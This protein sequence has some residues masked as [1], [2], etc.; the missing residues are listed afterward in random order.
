MLSTLSCFF[1]ISKD[2]RELFEGLKISRRKE[3]CEKW[4]NR[5]PTVFVSFRRVDGFS[6]DMAYGCLKKI[7]KELFHDFD[8][9]LESDA[10]RVED[11]SD[12]RKIDTE[13]GS[14][15]DVMFSL[16]LLTRMLRDHY[17]KKVVLLIDEYDVPMAKAAEKGYYREMLSVMKGVLS[18][19]KDNTSLEFSVITG[20]L[21]I[22]KESIFTGL[23][24]VYSNTVTK[25]SYDE[26]F[27]FLE[28][29]VED[30][31]RAIG[32]EDRLSLTK[33][34]YDGYHFGDTDIF[35]P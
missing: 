4:M 29:E 12:F 10:V 19:L 8:F 11:K 20:C 28:D 26:Y 25:N 6:F 32:I 9:L 31:Y 13:N 27:G 17:G 22:A 14:V 23:N 1:D 18:V 2:S 5:F 35:C 30:I 15:D 3:I 21:R 33:E 24:N 7:L 16:S 34:W